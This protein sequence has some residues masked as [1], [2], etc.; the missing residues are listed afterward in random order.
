LGELAAEYALA[1]ITADNTGDATNLKEVV[2][3]SLGETFEGARAEEQ[4]EDWRVVK[5][6]LAFP[7]PLKTIPLGVD[8]LTAFVDVQGDRFEVRVIGWKPQ[9]R[10]LSHR[11]VLNQGMAERGQCRPGQPPARLGPDRASRARYVVAA[12]DQQRRR[13]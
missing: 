5:Q 4:V 3:K 2:V 10:K 11:R 8:F 13:G 1:K 7:Y 9:R 12:V 6:R